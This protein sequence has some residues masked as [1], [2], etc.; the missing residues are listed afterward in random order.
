MAVLTRK[1]HYHHTI[2][3]ERRMHICRAG[4]PSSVYNL[5]RKTGETWCFSSFPNLPEIGNWLS[6]SN[7][8]FGN[9]DFQ[10][11]IIN[12]TAKILLKSRLQSARPC[13]DPSGKKPKSADT[14]QDLEV[15]ARA[16]FGS[17]SCKN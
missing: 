12:N 8:L 10:K 2:D 15:A 6:I 17:V 13:A 5:D 1:R 7:I 11:K 14:R 4:A 9:L 3:V 16:G